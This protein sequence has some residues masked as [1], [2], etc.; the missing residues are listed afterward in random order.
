MNNKTKLIAINHE[1]AAEDYFEDQP[2]AKRRRLDKRSASATGDTCS[3]MLTKSEIELLLKKS[4]SLTTVIDFLQSDDNLNNLMRTRGLCKQQIINIAKHARTAEVFEILLDRGNW[5]KLTLWNSLS[6]SDVIRTASHDGAARTL[7][8]LLKDS[9][10]PKLTDRLSV[11]D[12][13]SIASHSG[14]ADVLDIL[15]NDSNWHSLTIQRQLSISD[16]V[17]ISSHD[18]ATKTLNYLLQDSTWYT[19]K[20]NLLKSDIVNIPSPK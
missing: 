6:P 19:L 10:L 8:T 14:S 16:I 4:P 20:R 11:K 1:D 9:V 12:I 7:K 17:N 5:E 2:D 13:V 15:L 3:R 18:G